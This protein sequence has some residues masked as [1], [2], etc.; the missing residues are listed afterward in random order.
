MNTHKLGVPLVSQGLHSA[1]LVQRV[2]K[3]TFPE[4]K[5]THLQKLTNIVPRQLFG[6]QDNIAKIQ[7]SERE[8][9]RNSF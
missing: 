1:R 9:Y 7:E 3:V 8:T 4:R 5:E 6:I 2:P